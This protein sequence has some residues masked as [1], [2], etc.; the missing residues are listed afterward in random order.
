MI[1]LTRIEGKVKWGEHAIG[2]TNGT[3]FVARWVKVELLVE[4]SGIQ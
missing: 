2:T 4:R 3:K 1:T